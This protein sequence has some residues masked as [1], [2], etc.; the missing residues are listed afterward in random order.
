MGFRVYHFGRNWTRKVQMLRNG[1]QKATVK[2]YP[3]VG[4]RG[5]A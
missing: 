4:F 2:K 3:G 1:V 5:S